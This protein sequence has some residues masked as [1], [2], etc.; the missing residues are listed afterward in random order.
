[1]LAA[2]HTCNLQ[3]AYSSPAELFVVQQSTSAGGTKQHIAHTTKL[4][5]T[6]YITAEKS[7]AAHCTFHSLTL[8]ITAEQLTAAGGLSGTLQSLRFNAPSMKPL[9][10]HK[11][12]SHFLPIP[13]PVP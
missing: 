10:L 4:S 13:P 7:T 12:F 9:C 3:A 11:N 6:L 8:D 2:G 1:M 5:L